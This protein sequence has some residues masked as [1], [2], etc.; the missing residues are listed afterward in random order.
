MIRG[1]KIKK[2]EKERRRMLIA[3]KWRNEREVDVESYIV[4]VRGKGNRC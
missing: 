1:S 2:R 3:G 4:T